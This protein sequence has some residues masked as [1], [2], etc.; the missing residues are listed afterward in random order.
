MPQPPSRPGGR[1]RMRR[2]WDLG[3]PEIRPPCSPGP[4]LLSFRMVRVLAV[5]GGSCRSANWPTSNRLSPELRHPRPRRASLPDT[6][7]HRSLH[8]AGRAPGGHPGRLFIFGFCRL[9]AA[10]RSRRPAPALVVLTS[11]L[12]ACSRGPSAIGLGRQRG[13]VVLRRLHHGSRL[14]RPAR[15]RLLIG[16]VM[17]LLL[18]L[19]VSPAAAA[20]HRRANIVWQA[21]IAGWSASASLGGWLLSL[22]P[23]G[24]MLP[25]SPP[26]PRSSSCL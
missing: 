6:S 2:A 21:R 5:P 1:N 7:R 10:W 16:V 25:G 9:T 11:G 20:C 23:R 14:L 15:H 3:A 8:L 26:L 13:G 4:A 22:P 12:A 19:P 24:H 17:A 18:R